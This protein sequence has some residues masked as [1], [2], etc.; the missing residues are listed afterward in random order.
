MKPRTGDKR[1]EHVVHADK[2]LRIKDATPWE[3]AQ[4]LMQGG[5]PR[6]E[7]TRPKSR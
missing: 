4:K 7:E 2:D 5:A 3:V 6:R 1:E